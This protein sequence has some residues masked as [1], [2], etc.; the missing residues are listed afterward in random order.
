MAAINL[1]EIQ[2]LYPIRGHIRVTFILLVLHGPKF[3]HLLPGDHGTYY[4][5]QILYLYFV[6]GDL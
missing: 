4:R 5:P 6:Q 1:I 3:A 2:I